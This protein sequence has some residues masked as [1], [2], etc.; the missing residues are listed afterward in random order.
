MSAGIADRIPH[1]ASRPEPPGPPGFITR[2]PRRVPVAGCRVRASVTG[3][4]SAA[5]SNG[6]IGT[7]RVVHSQCVVPRSEGDGMPNVAHDPH[8]SVDASVD[9]TAGGSVDTGLDGSLSDA[10]GRVGAGSP[11]GSP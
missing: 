4:R 1:A 6:S 2:V 11:L 10:V 8:A 5:G 3:G 7:S 9:G